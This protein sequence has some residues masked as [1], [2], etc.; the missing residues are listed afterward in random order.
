MTV[1]L[2]ACEVQLVL[3]ALD[4]L[5]CRKASAVLLAEIE[6]LQADLLRSLSTLPFDVVSVAQETVDRLLCSSSSLPL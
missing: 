2:S 5:Q 3:A 1:N 4:E 6:S